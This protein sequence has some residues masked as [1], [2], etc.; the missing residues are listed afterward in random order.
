MLTPKYV[1][2]LREHITDGCVKIKRGELESV[3]EE[4]LVILS[5]SHGMMSGGEMQ[6]VEI[7]IN[8]RY[9]LRV[10]SLESLWTRIHYTL[11]I[12]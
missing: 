12:G 11:K 2:K 9:I 1:Y 7:W 8:Q 10:F 4:A 6:Y 5:K 3:Q